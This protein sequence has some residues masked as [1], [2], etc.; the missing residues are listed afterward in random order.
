VTNEV[1][2]HEAHEA[3]L[4]EAT[5]EGDVAALPASV[6]TQ[7][8]ERVTAAIAVP[9]PEIRAYYA[10]NLDLVTSAEVRHLRHRVAAT[11]ADARRATESIAEGEPWDLRR[12]EFWGPFEDAVF[13]AAPGGLIGPVESELGWHV[14]RVERI[15]PPSTRSFEDARDT[16]EADLLAAA[17]AR[18]FGE[19]L[20][21]RRQALGTIEPEWEHP[22]HPVHGNARHRH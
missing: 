20:E 7:L 2:A 3:G 5:S 9:E 1:L 21:E 16:I 13:A 8:F 18:A 11:E 19:W 10:R 12:G 14:A 15:D 17:R 6:L 4:I 22:A